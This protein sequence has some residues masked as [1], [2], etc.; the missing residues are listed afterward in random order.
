MCRMKRVIWEEGRIIS[1]E[2]GKS[3]TAP[4]VAEDGQVLAWFVYRS[5]SEV[6]NEELLCGRASKE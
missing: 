2:G 3:S 1:L 4:P 6:S 5:N